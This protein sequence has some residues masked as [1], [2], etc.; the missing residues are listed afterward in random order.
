[1]RKYNFRSSLS[2]YLLFLMIVHYNNEDLSN[3]N[4]DNTNFRILFE[5][6]DVVE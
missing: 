3:Q 4:S 5:A 6:E 2:V 1:M